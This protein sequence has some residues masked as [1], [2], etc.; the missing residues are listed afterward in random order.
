MQL[1]ELS[2]IPGWVLTHAQL[3]RKQPPEQK[4]LVKARLG[5]NGLSAVSVLLRQIHTI[6]VSLH[7]KC[8]TTGAQRSQRTQSNKDG[9]RVN[10]TKWAQGESAAPGALAMVFKRHG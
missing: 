3:L 9:C 8:H 4:S 10:G 1:C 5:W 7:K 2:P 6:H